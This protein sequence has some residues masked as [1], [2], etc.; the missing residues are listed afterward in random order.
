MDRMNEAGESAMAQD[1][2]ANGVAEV[3]KVRAGKLRERIKVLK[4][5]RELADAT[6]PAGS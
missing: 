1:Y 2:S 6:V 3:A 5:I 4:S